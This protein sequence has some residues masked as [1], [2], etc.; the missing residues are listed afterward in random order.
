M[1]NDN[2]STSFVVISGLDFPKRSRKYLM[3]LTKQVAEKFKAAFVIVAGHAMNGAYLENQL[4]KRL[5]ATRDAETKVQIRKDFIAE[6][7]SSF[8]EVLPTIKDVNYH[9][10]VAERIYDR[11]IG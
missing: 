1:N 6:M 2:A 9:I 4:K 7:A 11:E 5:K 8:N 10:V 3:D